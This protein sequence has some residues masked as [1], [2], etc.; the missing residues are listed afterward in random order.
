MSEGRE[1]WIDEIRHERKDLSF[2]IDMET[3][4]KIKQFSTKNNI[5][6]IDQAIDCL[7]NVGLAQVGFRSRQEVNEKYKSYGCFF[8]NLDFSKQDKFSVRDQIEQHFSNE[9]INV[10]QTPQ[11]EYGGQNTPVQQ[12]EQ[13]PIDNE[14]LNKTFDIIKKICSFS[15]DGNAVHY[16]ILMEAESN[17]IESRKVE[18]AINRLKQKGYIY[19]SAQK[20]YKVINAE[21]VDENFFGF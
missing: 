6:Q 1:S 9:R 8:D 3:F 15:D 17:G 5:E 16:D 10:N 19:E 13:K 14:L 18:E 20:R 2:N 7:I 4:G 21:K 11:Q 12:Q